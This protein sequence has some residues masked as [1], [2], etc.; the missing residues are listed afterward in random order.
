M[1]ET[2]GLLLILGLL[3]A[4]IVG[5]GSDHL[6]HWKRSDVETRKGCQGSRKAGS[7]GLKFGHL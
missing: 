6:E 1:K 3:V 7:Q 2:E 4:H 5:A